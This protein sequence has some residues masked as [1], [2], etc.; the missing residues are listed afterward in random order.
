MGQS[1]FFFNRELLEGRT[2]FDRCQEHLLARAIILLQT[3]D[4]YG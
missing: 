2:Y 1:D 4:D 3:R